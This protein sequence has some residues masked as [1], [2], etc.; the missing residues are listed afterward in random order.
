MNSLPGRSSTAGQGPAWLEKLQISLLVAYFGY[1]AYL[2]FGLPIDLVVNGTVDD[3]YYYLVVARNIAAGLG[4][5]FDGTTELTNVYHPLWMGF[6]VPIH[7]L[8]HDP[9]LGI[10]LTLLLSGILALGMLVLLVRTLNRN[11]GRWAGLSTLILFAWPRFFGLTQNAL[12]TALLLF[13]Y[14]WIFRALVR[15]RFEAVPQRTG[16]GILLGFAM[17]ARLDTVFLIFSVLLCSLLEWSRGGSLWT[18]LESGSRSGRHEAGQQQRA[19]GGSARSASM[20]SRLLSHLPLAAVAIPVLPYL[21]WNLTVFGHLQPVSGAMKTTFPS[22]GFHPGPLRDFPEYAALLAVALIVILIGLRSRASR[23]DRA[24][25]VFGIAAVLHALYTVLFMVWAVDRWH[26]AL[27]VFIALTALPGWAQ[28][29]LERIRRP[30]AVALVLLAIAGGVVVQSYS[31][32]LRSGRYQANTYDV[33][34]WARDH[35][36]PD[37]TLSST[38]SGVLAYFSGLSTVNLDGLINSF[39]Y[40]ERL[41][42]GNGAVERYMAEK[43]VDYILDQNSFGLT[44]VISGDYEDRVLRISYRPERRIAAEIPARPDLEVHRQVRSARRY[45]GSPEL[46]PNAII[47]YRFEH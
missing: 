22:V 46:E 6:V 7:L 32:S 26:F 5:T 40:L 15:G 47:L 33:A 27:L 29:I 41:R 42:E 4:S 23:Y 31:L 35:L 12:E 43:G 34:I 13:L 28:V 18:A 45:V 16:L 1:Y 14:A 37:A 20:W 3:S 10:R 25:A 8:V 2:A 9:D 24:L 17:L 36:P 38:D 21:F 11:V 30:I 19:A 39:A 44:D